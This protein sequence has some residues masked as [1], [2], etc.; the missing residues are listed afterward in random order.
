MKLIITLSGQSN[1]FVAAGYEEKPFIDLFG[2]S[3]IEHV[4]SMFSSDIPQEDIIFIC[5]NNSE[6][7]RSKLPKTFPKCKIVYI[8]PN[9]DGPVVSI[10]SA[11]LEND[12]DKEEEVIVSYCD[13]Y[14]PIN[15]CEML[16]Y[17]RSND[18]D[19]GVLTHNGFHPHRIYNSSFAYLRQDNENILEIKE[20]NH[21]TDNPINEPASSGVYYFN[22]FYQMIEYFK[23][24]VQSGNRVNN[25]FY[26]TMP[27]NLMIQD[28]MKI[29]S[30][31][32]SKYICLGTPKDIELIRAW[33][34]IIKYHPELKDNEILSSY[35]YLKNIEL[36]Y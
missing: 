18:A 15:V 20:K 3:I 32:T 19:G 4:V 26:V 16:N 30:Y 6:L 13:F 24:Y 25:E 1:R 7:S 21:F 14:F 36:L 23:K 9:K 27:Y 34:T 8:E 5:R 35:S 17:F 11:N 12:I 10:L 28:K 22:K 33:K 29:I 31:E 2:K